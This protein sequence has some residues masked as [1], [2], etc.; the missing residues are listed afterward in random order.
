MHAD[1]TNFLEKEGP[2][3]AE[4]RSVLGARARRG[5]LMDMREF[6]SYAPRMLH[7]AFGQNLL[8]SGCQYQAADFRARLEEHL[9]KLDGLFCHAVAWLGMAY[10]E[11]YSRIL[12]GDFVLFEFGELCAYHPPSVATK[13]FEIYRFICHQEKKDWQNWRADPRAWHTH[14]EEQRRRYREIIS[15]L[16]ESSE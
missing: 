8:Y 14:E 3:L 5:T 2:E 9:R 4:I 11:I 10:N 12:S 13:A 6:V 1:M 7:N 16:E 15:S